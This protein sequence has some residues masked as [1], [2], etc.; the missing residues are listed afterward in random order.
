MTAIATA[1]AAFVSVLQASPAVSTAIERVRLRPWKAGVSSAI[2]VRPL[3]ADVRDPQLMA[4]GVFAWDIQV[5]V[6]CYARAAAGTSP[7]AAVDSLISA[8]YA[9]LMTDTTLGG[10]VRS[11][12][13]LGITFEFDV[14]EQATACAVIAFSARQI[15]A[16]KT[17]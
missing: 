7:D 16:P 6:E 15:T 13:P 14:D 17:L 4:G 12:E 3:R 10:S 8:A 1:T 5:A 9:R 11:I 2:V